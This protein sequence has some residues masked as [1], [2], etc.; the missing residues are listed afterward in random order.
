MLLP[1]AT[2]MQLTLHLNEVRILCPINVL[3]HLWTWKHV[4]FKQK[5]KKT[6]YCRTIKNKWNHLHSESE[7]AQ[8]C[9]TL[10]NPMDCSKPGTS[11]R[12]WASPG[13]NT[14]V[15]CHFLLQGDL[16]NPGIEPRSPALQADA[17]TVWATREVHYTFIVATSKNKC[18]MLVWIERNPV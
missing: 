14:G 1:P 4:D 16:P 5:K 18:N 15:G 12:S 3:T 10:C 9:L 8:S 17:F 11:V 13:K 7:V 2:S 6:R